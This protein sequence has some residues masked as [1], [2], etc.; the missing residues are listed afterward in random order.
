MRWP[1]SKTTQAIIALTLGLLAGANEFGRFAM[2]SFNNFYFGPHKA[3][4]YPY[5]DT[6]TAHLVL[7][8]NCAVAFG[9]VFL[10][11]FA[12]LRLIARLKAN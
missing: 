11:A 10:G 4:P 12:L 7:A 2:R 9:I 1:R 8:R 6:R 3:Y 5:A